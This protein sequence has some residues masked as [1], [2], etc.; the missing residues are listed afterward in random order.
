MAIPAEERRL[1]RLAL[2]A[3]PLLAF[4][5]ALPQ[6]LLRGWDDGRFI[7]DNP[8][9]QHP[10]W[11]ALVRMFSSVQFEAYHP[12]HLLSYWIDVPWINALAGPDSL[13][14][15]CVVHAVSLALWICAL[16]GIF[17]VL[18]SL[19]VPAWG[20]ALGAL[21]TGLHPAQVEV[22][23][24]ASGRKDVLALLLCT[25]SLRL[26]LS[27]A[28]PWVARAWLSRA[29]YLA[30]VL[31]KTTA[32]PLPLFA[33]CIDV[34][35]RRQRVRTAVLWQLPS[36]VLG[37]GLSVVV[38]GI[39]QE[40][41]MLRGTLGG[42]AFALLRA[43]Q[44]LGHHLLTAVWPARV[45]PMYS[46]Q[47]IAQ[48]D[49]VR[50]LACLVYVGACVWAWRARRG[51]TLAGLL[52]FALWL[53]PASNLVPLYFPLQDRY[54]SLPLFALGCAIAGLAP[55]ALP[56]PDDR[57]FQL[58]NFAYL[59]LVLLGL[60]SAQYA[61]EWQSEPRLW[62]HAVRTQPG[63]EYAYLKLG[64][65][66]REAGDLE[67]AIAAYRA[68]IAR[69]PQRKLAFAGLFEVIARRDERQRQLAPSRARRL[70]Q[71]FYTILER[72]TGLRDLAGELRSYGYVR[73]LELPLWAAQQ[74]DPLPDAVLSQAALNAL[75]SG[76][77]SFAR[78]YVHLLEKPPELE[79]LK[80][81]G[82][83]PYLRVVP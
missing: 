53:A 11:A 68:G 46:T 23:C 8:D 57:R 3:L 64:E 38:Y 5:R 55:Q 82:R 22:V 35:A 61:G 54:L 14:T 6:P 66:R 21:F 83:E 50:S 12:L 13:V 15:A 58:R 44:T 76:Q 36:L 73:A 51:L 29:L 17:T 10:S 2:V 59:A 69:W 63:A 37:A 72:P 26:Q 62:G 39:W 34:L 25:A 27:A 75:Q 20:A 71:T 1:A 49:W 80:S 18:C 77:R 42:P 78:F 43:S 65:A 4:G 41:S 48:L 79:P 7:I 56:A 81:L 31:A 9:V 45:S 30:A 19:G 32:L 33:L 67:G 74:Q 47:S 70:A 24:W 40:H 16:D 60:R 28:G 52:G